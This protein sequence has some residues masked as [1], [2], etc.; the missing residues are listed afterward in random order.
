MRRQTDRKR[1]R[2]TGRPERLGVI[3]SIDNT[4]DLL[5]LYII[6]VIIIASCEQL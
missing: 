2:Q 3:M 5:L 6:S 1:E 4:I